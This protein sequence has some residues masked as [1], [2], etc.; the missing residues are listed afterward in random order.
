[1]PDY[2]A[3]AAAYWL[4]LVAIG[5]LVIA[6]AAVEVGGLRGDA[7]LQVLVGTATA[8]LVGF[9]PVRL[10]GS[11]RSIAAGD[12]FVFLLLL[13]G[14]GAAVLG[15]A[16]EAAV[17]SWRTSERLT[18]RLANP[19]SAAIAIFAS[20]ALFDR[21]LAFLGGPGVAG[22]VLLGALILVAIGYFLAS[23]TLITALIHLKRG[24]GVTAAAWLGSFVWVGLSYV[25][26]ASI[27]GLLFLTQHELGMATLAVAVP[28]IAMF[29][30]TLH[31][32]FGQQEAAGRAARERVEAAE[33]EAAQA[34]RYMRELKSSEKRFQ[35]AFTHASI[36]MAL[37]S[38]DG[39]LLQVNRALC[40]LL[41]YDEAEVVGHVIEEFVDEADREPLIAQLARL[42]GQRVRTVSLELRCHHR[43]GTEVF[44]SLAASFF[45]EAASGNPLLIFQV[46]D[47]TARRR[48]EDRLHHIA[49]H[50]PLT[51]LAN[52]ARFN[53]CLQQAIDRQRADPERHFAVLFLDFDR[54]KV[55]NDSLGHRAGDEFLVKVAGRIREHVR[56]TDVV[57]RLGGDE[58]AILSDGVELARNAVA[59]A[60]RLQ[61]VLRVPVLVGRNEVSTSASIGITFSGFGYTRPD[62]VL[63]DADI[64]MYRAK[65]RGKAQYALFDA[66]LHAHIAAQL[67]LE[68]D[69]RRAIESDQF[70]LEY[71]PLYELQ[72]G[73]LVAFEALARWNHPE[74]GLVP[75]KVFIPAAEE[76]GLIGP[77]TRHLLERACAQFAAWHATHR[78]AGE[79]RLHVNIS[80]ADLASSGLAERVMGT[81]LAFGLQPR[82]V[83]LE[84]TES[85]LMERLDAVLPALE[86]LSRL[87]VG[88]SV[89]DFGTGYSSLAYL[90]T[91]PI[92][93]LKIDG[94]FVGRLQAG[95]ENSEVVRAV[96]TLGKALGKRVIAEGIETSMQMSRLQELGCEVGQGFH[97]S[98]P[99]APGQAD[100]LLSGCKDPPSRA[101]L[102]RPTLAF[103]AGRQVE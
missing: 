83:T 29:L 13:H 19:A 32:Y 74:R 49:Y 90:S 4:A 5:A 18:S 89:D 45:D 17:C 68:G 81:I 47:V 20:G 39:I 101:D 11:K 80:G 25:A 64:A 72:S 93:S 24:N 34:A 36:G 7:L 40:V 22:N 67:Q 100:L 57:A 28:I 92:T 82:H 31:Y 95:A 94:S 62:E 9:F 50:D 27:A 96:I 88:V 26:S 53:E 23:S 43:L 103:S 102:S 58:F 16:A 73:R 71:Q 98:R 44:A 2:G 78:A 21:V 65:E 33:R 87:G 14:P 37:A 54:F 59:L 41:G 99:V 42:G 86:K 85:T 84:I 46:Q 76:A 55:I 15:A 1:M 61:S 66:S 77:L 69:L 12:I 10:P 51:D 38:V 70:V 91:L 48:A 6:Q 56:P 63:R 3:G 75:P 97:M 8:G 35:S 52:R 79:L 60:E 30:T